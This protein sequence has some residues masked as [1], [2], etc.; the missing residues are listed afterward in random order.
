VGVIVLG[1]GAY[2]GRRLQQAKGAAKAEV[3]TVPAA[4]GTIVKNISSTG[5]IAAQTGA[6]INIGS[7]ISGR[8][9]KVFVDLGGEVTAG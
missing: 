6:S 9:K 2:L 5:T 1:G 7:Q 4:R 8:I 3:T